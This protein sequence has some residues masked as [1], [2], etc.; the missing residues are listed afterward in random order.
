MPRIL[1]KKRHRLPDTL[2]MNEDPK[3]LY[4]KRGIYGEL[5]YGSPYIC[6]GLTRVW[7]LMWFRKDWLKDKKILAVGSGNGFEIVALRK[8]GYDVTGLDLF[9]PDVKM[10]KEVSIVGDMSRMPF[11]N[12]QFDLITCF[13]TLEH[14]NPDMNDVIL[15]ECKRVA[16]RA[17]FSISIQRDLPYDTHINVHTPEWWIAKFGELGFGINHMQIHPMCHFISSEYAY[18]GYHNDSIMIDVGC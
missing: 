8:A 11:K 14:I 3:V 16:D 17:I 7:Q 9:V 1:D 5:V 2:W 6:H 15:G 13:E 12:K 18:E 4:S 10:V